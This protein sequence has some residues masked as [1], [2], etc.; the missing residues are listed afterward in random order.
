MGRVYQAADPELDRRIALKLVRGRR[1]DAIASAR[2]LREAQALAQLAHP[3]VVTVF[4]AGRFGD[5]VYL[6]MELVEGTTLRAWLREGPRPRDKVL[7][8]LVA[9]GRG[10]AAA[11]RA[12]LVHRDFKPSNVILGDDGRVRVL[13]FGIARADVGPA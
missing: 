3:N 9:A 1:G 2:L 12:G 6:A 11:H 13:D 4:D 10:L 8:V 7:E 5:D